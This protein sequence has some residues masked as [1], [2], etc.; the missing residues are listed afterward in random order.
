MKNTALL[1]AIILT[2][3]ISGCTMDGG[4][5]SNEDMDK[6]VT[7]KD[8]RDGEVFEF[9]TNTISNVRRGL[10]VPSSFDIVTID[11]KKMTLNSSMETWLKC[12][13]DKRKN[14]ISKNP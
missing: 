5:L 1:M 11:G 2:S 12:E 6:I 13:K 7:C 9:N 4:S 10:G 14:E 3:F 8:A